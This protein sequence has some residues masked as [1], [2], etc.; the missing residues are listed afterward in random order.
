LRR[1]LREKILLLNIMVD[2]FHFCSGTRIL[3]PINA[4]MYSVLEYGNVCD[5]E[6]VEWHMIRQKF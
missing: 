2:V 6:T 1:N 5:S 3:C 4:V